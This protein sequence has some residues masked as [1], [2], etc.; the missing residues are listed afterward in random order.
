MSLIPQDPG[1]ALNPVKTIGKQ[2]AEILAIHGHATGPVAH[3]Q[4][5]ELLERVGLSEPRLARSNIPMSFPAA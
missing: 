5:I 1:N 3:S 2:V 4:A